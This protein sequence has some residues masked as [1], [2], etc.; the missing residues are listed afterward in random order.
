MKEYGGYIELDTYMHSMLH[1]GAVA[2]NSGRS[3]LG[4]LIQARNIKKV[5]LPYLIC[6]SMI[7]VCEKY[8]TSARFYSINDQFLPTDLVLE[9][10]EWLYVVNFYGQ[11]TREQL[12][13]I[14][15]RYGR[16]IVDN[17]QAYFDEPLPE[18]DTLY[19]CRKFFGVPDGSF[20]YTDVRLEE[21]LEQDE[22]FERMHFLLGRFERTASEFYREYSENN[23][24]FAKEP[25]K[26]MSKL[27]TNLLHGIDYSFVKSKR[28]KNY[29]I[30]HSIFSTIN[31][32]QLRVPD[33]AFAYPLMVNDGTKLRKKL[34]AEKIYI[35]MLWPNVIKENVPDT[36]A[37]HFAENILPIPCDQRYDTEEIE[38]V[39]N[40]IREILHLR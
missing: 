20:L 14:K 3:C 5:L 13:S 32:L 7:E 4:Y 35:P 37:C 23:H 11:L 26:R 6:D 34:Q 9:E 36:I 27:T 17:A 1:E 12:E 31:Q 16:V 38:Y 15:K 19:T 40:R 22:S 33:G 24:R 21:E 25:I 29:S 28:T 30:Y 8:G 2:L 39:A 10:D 18:T